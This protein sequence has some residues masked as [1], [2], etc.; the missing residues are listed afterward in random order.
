[1]VLSFM[2]GDERVDKVE[3]SKVPDR[4]SVGIAR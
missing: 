3:V 2:L 4:H 1:M